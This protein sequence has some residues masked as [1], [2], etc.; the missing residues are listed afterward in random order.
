M[1]GD[2]KILFMGTPVFALASLDVMRKAGFNIAAVVTAPDKPAGRGRK[3][4]TS[5]VK[6]YAIRH[7]LP[8]LQPEKMKDSAFLEE[9][10]LISPDLIIVVA[11]RM[12]PEEV[13]ALPRLGTINLHASLLP[14]YRGAAPINRAIMNGEKETGVTSFFIEKEIDTGK[15][16]QW[17]ATP[18]FEDDNAGSLHDRL[19]VTGAEL[20]VET[21]RLVLQDDPPLHS[22]EELVK[23]AGPLKAAPKIFPG[24]CRIDWDRPVAEVYNHIRGLSP[25]PTAWTLIRITDGE[26][27]LKIFEAVKEEIATREKP[28]TVI[29]EDKR[30]LVACRDGY[31]HI[32]SLQVEGKKRMP[33]DDFIRGA[34]NLSSLE[35]I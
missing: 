7:D 4:G 3:L 2:P 28:G 11:F 20:L 12:L 25:Y 10:K 1:T 19:M 30:L 6:D 32:L 21:I 35:I 26:K 22:Q 15:I 34:R 23:K 5:P 14:Q 9:L 24:D 18:V 13:W 8:V 31:I 16:I 27:V 29:T 33:V 17:R